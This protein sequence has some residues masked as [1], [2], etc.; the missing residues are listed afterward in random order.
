MGINKT[1]SICSCKHWVRFKLLVCLDFWLLTQADTVVF[2]KKFRKS[3]WP[4][5]PPS[6]VAINRPQ[7][8]FYV[9]AW[10]KQKSCTTKYKIELQGIP[11]FRD[12]T[13]RAPRY[14]VILFETK[15]HPK[16]KSNTFFWK[17]FLDFFFKFLFIL[18][19]LYTVIAT[20]K[21]QD[22]LIRHDNFKKFNEL[23]E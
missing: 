17:N 6:K 7:L 8:F 22:L 13:I 18:F 4:R 20:D 21:Y 14:F 15:F 3:F 12:F 19:C 5:K 9:L 10:L 11:G 23:V 16:K 2:S 1:E